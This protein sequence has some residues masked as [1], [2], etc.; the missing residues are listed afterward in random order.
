MSEFYA[1]FEEYF[2]LSKNDLKNNITGQ[3]DASPGYVSR[4]DLPPQRTVPSTG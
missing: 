4:P 2:D 3:N 1:E